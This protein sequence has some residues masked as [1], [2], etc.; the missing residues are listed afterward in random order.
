M[1][2][3][4]RAGDFV[5]FDGLKGEIFF[6][7]PNSEH[8][9]GGRICCRLPGARIDMPIIPL[10]ADRLAEEPICCTTEPFLGIGKGNGFTLQI[11]S[12]PRNDLPPG[13]TSIRI[14]KQ[15]VIA[16]M[17]RARDPRP[18]PEQMAGLFDSAGHGA[19]ILRWLVAC[20]TNEQTN[21]RLD[22]DSITWSVDVPEG[23]RSSRP[24]PI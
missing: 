1:Q 16:Y 22:A 23:P 7:A 14:T 5:I 8:R 11:R 19:S 17:D 18:V 20:L 15:D 3:R 24:R 12:L 10:F 9:I 13:I 2:D 21:V 4:L 6:H